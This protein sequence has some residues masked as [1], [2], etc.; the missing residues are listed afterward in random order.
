MRSPEYWIENIKTELYNV[1]QDYMDEHKLN[2]T[3]LAELVGVT[4]GY[5]S[6]VLNGSSDHR[7]SKLVNLATMVGKAPYIYFK[8][9]NAVIEKDKNDQSAYIDF[10]QLELDAEKLGRKFIKANNTNIVRLKTHLNNPKAYPKCYTGPVDRKEQF[11]NPPSKKYN[12][13][14]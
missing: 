1:I 11:T 5:I 12:D 4:K 14:A 7:I 6:Q 3:Q 2:R 10:Q 8:D 9:L 13:V